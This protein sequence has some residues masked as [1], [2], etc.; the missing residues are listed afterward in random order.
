ME[1]TKTPLVHVES[2]IEDDGLLLADDS[3]I[4]EA[5][6]HMQTLLSNVTAYLA[7]QGRLV[8]SVS[9]L[10]LIDNGEFLVN[11]IS[12]QLFLDVIKLATIGDARAMRYSSTVKE[13]F[14]VDIL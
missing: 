3:V 7:E 5:N 8:E 13:I 10:N 9:F 2:V 6:L 14:I 4:N 11:H 1:D 12:L